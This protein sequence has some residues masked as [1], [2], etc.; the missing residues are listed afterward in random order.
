M[1]SLIYLNAILLAA[2]TIGQCV[3]STIVI[4]YADSRIRRSSSPALT[5]EIASQL[6]AA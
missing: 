2:G 6:L 5:M 3:A 4:T 1:P